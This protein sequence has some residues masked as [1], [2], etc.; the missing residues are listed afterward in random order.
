[1]T[2]LLRM[3]VVAIAA[4]SAVLLLAGCTASR[5]ASSSHA[6]DWRLVELAGRLVADADYTPTMTLSLDEGTVT[7]FAACNRYH[8]QIEN[9]S[10]SALRFGPLAA[11]KMACLDDDR[12][13]LEQAFLTM[14]GHVAGR[15]SEGDG[16]LIL[17]D[18]DGR[19]LARFRR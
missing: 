1:M 10:G 6:G 13:E 4:I 11:T 14:L 16:E 9:S 19:S 8:G 7:G 12:M 2:Y 5:S 3:S 17:L 18:G 15:R